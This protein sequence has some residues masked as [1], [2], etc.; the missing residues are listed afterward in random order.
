MI[1][2]TPAIVLKSFPYS[3]TSII[4]RCFSKDQGKVS[5]IVKGAR[6]KSSPKTAHFQPLGYIEMIYNNKPDRGLQVLS[7]VDFIEFWPRIIEDL[8]AVTL[9]MTILEI[10]DKTLSENDPYPG[11]FNTLVNVLRMY[12]EQKT[13]PN[14]LFWFYE[15]ALLSHLGF[16]PSLDKLEF[17]GLTLVDLDSGPNSR[18]ILT[19]LLKENMGD[20][21]SE[22]IMAKDRKVISDYLWTLLRYHCDGLDKIKSMDVAR[23]I[24]TD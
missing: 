3:D 16:R 20:L 17:P 5:I 12:N 8:K 21:P 19:K 2:H 24:L 22:P 9:S 6:S 4:A 1:V 10:T 13:N 23:N 14:L 7:K 18:A 11:L 15:C